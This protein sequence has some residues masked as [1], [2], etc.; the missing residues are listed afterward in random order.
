MHRHS[1]LASHSH[2]CVTHVSPVQSMRQFRNRRRGLAAGV[3]HHSL[4]P[5]RSNGWDW[6]GRH[7]LD[8]EAVASLGL[9]REFN[10]YHVIKTLFLVVTTLRNLIYHVINAWREFN[11]C[12]LFC[13]NFRSVVQRENSLTLIFP[14]ISRRPSFVCL[15]VCPTVFSALQPFCLSVQ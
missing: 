4:L 6:D 7:C 2:M 5:R 8:S 10:M 11:R 14:S 12:S 3:R 1:V 13:R 15:S 9:E